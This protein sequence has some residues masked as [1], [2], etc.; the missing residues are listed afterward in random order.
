MKNN[1]LKAI[2]TKLVPLPVG[3]YSQAVALESAQRLVFVSGQL[4]IDMATGKLADENITL[5]TR[6]ILTAI[7]NIL[8]E[9]GSSMENVVR[10]EIFCTALKQDFVAINNEYALHFA[11]ETKPARQTIEVSA[12][13]MG[14]PVEISCIAAIP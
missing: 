5:M 11:D 1:L 12:L 2:Q 13:P 9:S 3:P 8:A 7:K 14:S 10:V 6:R 4:P